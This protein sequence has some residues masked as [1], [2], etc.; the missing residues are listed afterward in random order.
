MNLAELD[1]YF[2]MSIQM[3][4]LILL[5]FV[6]HLIPFRSGTCF[7][8]FTVHPAAERVSHSSGAFMAWSACKGE[9]LPSAA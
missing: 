3:K 2:I 1:L 4:D 6:S 7:L 9:E 8:L 5:P